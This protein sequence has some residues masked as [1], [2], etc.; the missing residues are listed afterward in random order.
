VLAY[1]EAKQMQS[2]KTSRHESVNQTVLLIN[3]LK[4]LTFYYSFRHK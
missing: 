3:L 4:C 2:K 1:I